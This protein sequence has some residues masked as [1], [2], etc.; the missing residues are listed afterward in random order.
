MMIYEIHKLFYVLDSEHLRGHPILLRYDEIMSKN[1]TA[2][3]HI[4]SIVNN[5]S[6]KDVIPFT[7][8]TKETKVKPKIRMTTTKDD[9]TN[10]RDG[11]EYVCALT[12]FY[13][14]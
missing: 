6:L 10:R 3:V 12:W 1:S 9:Y 11:E 2:L 4:E 14:F 5:W 8:V 13:K 7:S